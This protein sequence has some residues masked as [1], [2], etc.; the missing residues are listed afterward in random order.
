MDK[1]LRTDQHL[2]LIS[3]KTKQRIL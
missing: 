3:S 1:Q 2:I